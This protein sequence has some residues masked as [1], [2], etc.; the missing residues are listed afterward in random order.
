MSL[1]IR[2]LIILC[3]LLCLTSCR[4]SQTTSASHAHVR[5]NSTASV[6]NTSVR[7]DTTSTK[8]ITQTNQYIFTKE[9][10]IITEYDTSKPG[11]PVAKTTTTEKN[12]IQGT[13]ADAELSNQSVTHITEE[14][15]KEESTDSEL[16][17]DTDEVTQVETKEPFVF[18]W[19]SF[20]IIFVP[21]ILFLLKISK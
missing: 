16:I 8:L 7:A 6:L 14:Q 5:E 3:W 18:N 10:Q 9:T 11:N 20:I 21:T 17:A 2:I 1:P 13:Q 4:S 12:T 19:V 15:S